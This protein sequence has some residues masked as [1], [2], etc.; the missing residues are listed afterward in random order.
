MKSKLDG[1]SAKAKLLGC[2]GALFVAAILFVTITSY[3]NF[4][5]SSVKDYSHMLETES[6]L[7]ANAL[8]QKVTRYFD[9][10]QIVSDSLVID[11]NGNIDIEDTKGKLNSITSSLDTLAAYVGLKSGVTYLPNGEIPNFNA[12]SLNREWYNRV[13]AGEKRIITTPYTS[14]SGN[15][16]MALAV[17]V[18]RDGQIV[19]VLSTNIAVDGITQ[20]IGNLTKENQVFVSR[21]DGFILAAKDQEYVGSNLYEERPSYQE[22]AG[23]TGSQHTYN[24]EGN[25]Y[26]VINANIASYGWNIWAW[27]LTDNM[28]EASNSNFIQGFSV[29]FFL[30]IIALIVIYVLVTKLMYAPI[31]GEPRVIEA[32]VKRVA[33]GDLTVEVEKNSTQ[34]GVYAATLTM[35]NNLKEIIRDIDEAMEQ[36][37]QASGNITVSASRVN[38][39]SEKQMIQLE[40]TST[41]MNEMTVTVD[42][43][44]RNAM[45]ASTAAKEANE[46]SGQGMERVHEMNSN[47]STL[48]TGIEKVMDVISRLEKET[49]DIGS[50]L[51]VINDIS[52]QTNLLALNAAI[53]AARAGEHGRGFAVV[54]DEVR[55]LANRTKEST[56]EIQDMINRLQ[57]EAKHSV[58]LMEDNMKDVQ[59]TADKS[60]EASQALQSIRNSVSV[61]Q[62]MNV[63][64]ATAA[65]EQTHVASEINSSVVEIND[66]AKVTFESSSGNKQMSAK[67]TELANKLERCVAMFKL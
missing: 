39:S 65:E 4:K 33:D 11:V 13:F 38:E 44:A 36:M 53:E 46:F 35:I 45:E 12:K 3:S 59:S 61:I 55:N 2:I 20:F 63:Q 31:G 15:L 16:V 41:A 1:M 60:D 43:V 28:Y 62:D 8:E 54:A 22:Y 52:E 57:G 6:F 40:Q 5:S 32:L 42:E 47:M 37:N 51:E 21:S 26:F 48:V 9:G 10:L 56:N 17:P 7:I 30:I 50:I 29:S 66:L 27:D 25:E 19:A 14:S 23:R 67:L 18:I 64:I 49:Q 58:Q 24:V 34:T